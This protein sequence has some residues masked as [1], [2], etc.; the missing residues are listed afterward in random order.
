M[1]ESKSEPSLT[2]KEY[3]E[4][5]LDAFKNETKILLASEA[6]QRRISADAIAKALEL[7]RD[8]Y[9]RRLADLN[10]AHV[11]AQQDKNTYLPRE[12]FEGFKK[13]FELWKSTT[14]EQLVLGR[15][16]AQQQAKSWALLVT[17]G[18]VL[19]NAVILFVVRALSA[20]G[21]AP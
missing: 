7:Q 18:T 15:V 11:Q 3:F 8:E 5:Q 19:L 6:S 1:S 21:I 20:V 10:H 16:N 2:L 12:V 14:A 17:V 4:I 13:E 9:A